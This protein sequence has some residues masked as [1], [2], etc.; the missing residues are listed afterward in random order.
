MARLSRATLDDLV[1]S[2]LTEDTILKA[3]IGDPESNPLLS[4]KLRLQKV[5]VGYFLPYFY[6][7]GKRNGH[8]RIKVLAPTS[9]PKYLQKPRTPNHAYCPPGPLLPKNWTKDTD[10]PLV[11]TEGEKKALAACQWGFPTVGI[12]GVASWRT[13]RLAVSSDNVTPDPENP[14][15]AF[16][17]FAKGVWSLIVVPEFREIQWAGREVT[18]AFDSDSTSN[19][20]VQTAAFELGW[21]LAE[22]GASVGQFIMPALNEGTKTGLDDYLG[23]SAE[24]R[25]EFH[26]ALTDFPLPPHP[27]PWLQDELNKAKITRVQIRR[28]AEVLLS[29]VDNW[30]RRYRDNQDNYYFFEARTKVLHPFRLE[31]T[32]QLRST[33]FGAVLIQ[34]LGLETAD[35]QVNSRFADLFAT[36]PTIDK[37]EPRRVTYA[38]EEAAYWQIGDGR[39]AKITADEIALLDNGTDNVLFLPDQVVPL[40]E[41]ALVAAIEKVPHVLGS[42]WYDALA[43]LNLQALP[44]LTIEQTRI[45][46]TCVF[47]LSPW[48]NRWRG[49]QLPLEVAVAEPNSGKTFLYNLRLGIL[50][51]KPELEGMPDDFRGWVSAVSA[52]PGLWVADN[53]GNV[54]SDYW[55]RFNDELARLVTDPAPSIELRQLYTTSTVTRIPIQAAFAVTAVKNPFTAP[56]V[57]QRSLIYSMRAIPSGERDSNWYVRRIRDRTQWVAGHLVALQQFLT[58][59]EERWNPEY[60]SGFRLVHLEQALLLMGE[61]IGYGNEIQGVVAELPQ[62]TAQTVAEYDPVIE[63]LNAFAEEHTSPVAT[64]SD[65]VEWATSDPEQRYNAIKTLSNSILLGRYIWGHAYDIEQS[66][67]MTPV[68]RHNATVLKLRT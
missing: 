67:G 64:P 42:L 6:T 61:A 9:L 16:V 30:G 44:S 28:I 58:L 62:M 35:T 3:E 49:L 54:R 15:T 29:V 37:V 26:Y 7:N 53:L 39:L 59:V 51:G 55:H 36:Q 13:H 43:T 34:K 48:L 19:P 50:T 25:S 23:A 11:I 12:G 52:A 21:W 4:E 32:G 20:G 1:K 45:L 10:I 5:Q 46:L 24:N 68:K 40:N 57:L 47:H 41:D 27:K 60:R 65:V 17:D 2:G 38:S 56:D 33:S 8:Y 22:Q 31:Q 14:K 18:I 63:A 66:T